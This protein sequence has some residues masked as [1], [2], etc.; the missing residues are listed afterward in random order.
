MVFYSTGKSDELFQAL[1]SN[2]ISNMRLVA[3]VDEIPLARDMSISAIIFDR[4]KLHLIDS[5]R[6]GLAL[7]QYLYSPDSIRSP[8][9]MRI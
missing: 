1:T 2:G 8:L 4:P 3:G 7:M 6:E 9:R 5:R